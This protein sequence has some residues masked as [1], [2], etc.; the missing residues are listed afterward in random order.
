MKKIL[1]VGKGLVGEA[2]ESYFKETPNEIKVCSSSEIDLRILSEIQSELRNFKPDV[3][4]FAAGISGGIEANLQKPGDL[5]MQ[6]LLMISNFLFAAHESKVPQL[7]NLVP[8]CVYPANLHR[9]LK[10]RDLFASP[11]EDSSLAYSTAK[12]AGLITCQALASQYDLS[13]KSV[14]ITNLYGTSKNQKTMKPHVIPDLISKFQ[15]AKA[16]NATQIELFG[17][18]LP[19]RDFLHVSDLGSAI[20]KILT[21]EGSE[22]I[23]N[24]NGSG[25]VTIAELAIE[26]AK[27]TKFKG[28]I[29]FSGSEMNGADFKVLDGTEIQE[30]GWKPR[31]SLQEGLQLL[32]K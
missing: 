8:A 11:M 5:A 12:L 1:V 30:L 29:K 6:N 21:S 20:E 3:A 22:K 15:S 28:R 23:I 19:V 13:W 10:P 25:E 27:I 18:G 31:I 4:I 16:R 17:N 32:M 14:V 24:I 7:L 9:R 26:I 2:V